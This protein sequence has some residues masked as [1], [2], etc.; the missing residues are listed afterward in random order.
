MTRV[1]P[2]QAEGIQFL[3]DYQTALTTRA[4]ESSWPKHER[5]WL[6]VGRC[7]WGLLRPGS[8]NAVTDIAEKMH[9]D[10]EQLERFV[11]E[12]PWTHENVESELRERVPEAI[13]GQE[14][15]LIVD[16]IGIPKSGDESV[17]VARQWCGATGKLDNCQVIINCTLA[18]PGERQNADQLTWSLGMRLFLSER[19]TGDDDADYDSQQERERYAQRR[20]DTDVPADAEH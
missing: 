11:R 19:R 14:A 7:F 3:S 8:S 5:T 18:R 4:D 17:G 12:S 16:G 20:E 9:I 6:N 13:Q 1:R 10:R 15:A 2:K